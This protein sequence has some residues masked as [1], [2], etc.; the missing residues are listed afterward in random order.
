[1]EKKAQTW[2][3]SLFETEIL[4]LT[5]RLCFFCIGSGGSGDRFCRLFLS[6]FGFSR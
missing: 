2:P 4:P 6:G 3:R 5:E 1:M